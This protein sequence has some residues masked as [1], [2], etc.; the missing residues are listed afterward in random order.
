[1]G[2]CMHVCSDASVISNSYDSMD[3]GMQPASSALQDDSLPLNQQGF[4]S[5]QLL[6]WKIK[7]GPNE[8]MEVTSIVRQNLASKFGFL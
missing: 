5:K 1:M 7:I 6:T 2:K 3:P 4:P 8:V